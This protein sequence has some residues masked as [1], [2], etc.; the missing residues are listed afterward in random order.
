M[1]RQAGLR[2]AGKALCPTAAAVA[3]R[4]DK[5]G[6]GSALSLTR[7]RPMIPRLI[8]TAD[9]IDLPCFLKKKQDKYG[10][11]FSIIHSRSDIEK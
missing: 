1:L 11:N 2:L 10:V 8:E 7:F 3:F 9:D 5:H 6:F 4:H